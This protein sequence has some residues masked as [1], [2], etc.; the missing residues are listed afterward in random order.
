MRSGAELV[1][2]HGADTNDDLD[3]LI[4]YSAPGATWGRDSLVQD[5]GGSLNALG[6]NTAYWSMSLQRDATDACLFDWSGNGHH[7]WFGGVKKAVIADTVYGDRGLIL[8]GIA[9]N[10]ATVPSAG[11]S[12]PTT[13]FEWQGKVR[14]NDWTP[15]S[16]NIL[17]AR[18]AGAQLS[19]RGFVSNSGGVLVLQATTDGTTAVTATSSAAPTV[20]DTGVIWLKFTWRASDGRVQFFQS[21]D[22]VTWTQVG[23]DK[24]IAI[25]S[26]HAGTTALTIG[27]DSDGSTPVNGV[28]YRQLFKSAID[29]TTVFDTGDLGSLAQGT[30]SFT[31]T[32]GQTVTVNTS[33]TATSEP[34]QLFYTGTVYAWMP[35]VASNY[36]STP[37]AAALDITGDIDIRAKVALTD[38]TPSADMVICGKWDSPERSYRLVVVAITGVI[39][40]VTSPDGTASV[41]CSSTVAPTVTDGADLWIRATL[42]V[43][44]GAGVYEANF[45]TSANGSTWTKLG[46]TVVGGATTSIYSG[47]GAFTISG[48]T[49]G[50][51]GNLLG[52]VYNVQLFSGI[53]GTK[54]LD[55]DF[56]DRS[57]YA[58]RP[59]DATSLTAVTGQ[60]VTIN[61][62]AT[63]LK[64]SIVDENKV[65]FDGSDDYISVDDHARLDFGD[66][67][68]FTIAARIIAHH[69][70]PAFRETILAK[71]TTTT[72][73]NVAGYT[74]HRQASGSA[75][76]LS[77]GDSG[78]SSVYA[79]AA[80]DVT[81]STS[82]VVAARTTGLVMRAFVTGVGG[83]EANDTV[84]D[85][86]N[87]S[88]LWFGSFTGGGEY[89]RMEMSSAAL[90]RRALTDTQ[91]LAL[92]REM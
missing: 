92:N 75:F 57:K 13:G 70:A 90:F 82:S 16:S 68:A 78:S 2:S 42:D 45:Y 61:R 38:W 84:G 19:F 37:D 23:T 72:G 73:A 62:S 64:T 44:N 52:K 81:V 40:I 35:N 17:F 56:T 54:V 9:S 12:W 60:T 88:A 31:A 32:T 71:R 15:S 91:I 14:L 24:A 66:D 48:I 51:S 26:I 49:S 7:G 30:R 76:R 25:A 80:S 3:A 83:T 1:R 65:V 55:I 36:M 69:Q 18:W 6:A 11:T 34:T 10:T 89:A 5:G 41:T 46:D 22:A 20:A 4:Q 8:P 79:S 39:R 74:I 86:S 50:S 29:G 67:V 47:S 28:I 85:K 43:D 53:A 77:V 87:S 27:A 63:G 58:G 59:G 33:G 21:D